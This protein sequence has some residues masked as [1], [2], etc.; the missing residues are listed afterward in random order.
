MFCKL[1]LSKW[2][3]HCCSDNYLITTGKRFRKMND[4]C[5]WA[6]TMTGVANEVV[7]RSNA[8]LIGVQL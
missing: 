2:E 1:G 6:K 4:S 5:V 7:L 8:L 3:L